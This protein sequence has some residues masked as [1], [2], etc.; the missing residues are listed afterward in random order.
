E[1]AIFLDTKHPDHYRVYN[2]CSQKGYDPLFFH[3]RVQRVMIDDHNVPSLD[4]MLNYTASLRECHCH[5][6]Q[7]RQR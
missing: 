5:P 2:L 4:D 3:Y 1:A 6:L 7:R